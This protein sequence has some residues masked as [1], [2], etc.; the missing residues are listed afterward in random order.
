M[1]A[2]RQPPDGTTTSDPARGRF[3]ASF[4]NVGAGEERVEG[5]L[6]QIECASKAIAFV[7][8]VPEGTARLSPLALDQIEFITYSRRPEGGDRC[9]P[10]LGRPKKV[11]V[12]GDQPDRKT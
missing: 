7:L 2:H 11:Y 6:E 3:V 10:L 9:G 1:T 8:R 4:R 5:E 12:P